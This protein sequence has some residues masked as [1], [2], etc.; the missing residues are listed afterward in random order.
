MSKIMVVD[1]DP[2]GQR[3]ISYMLVPE[4]NEV[5]TASNGIQGLQMATEQ[6]PDLI[7]LDVML[8]GLDGFDK[9]YI[10]GF[11]TDTAD[12]SPAVAFKDFSYFV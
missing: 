7:I 5:I 6:T 11:F 1:D 10:A 9:G 4:G 12:I 2:A 8:P 3:L